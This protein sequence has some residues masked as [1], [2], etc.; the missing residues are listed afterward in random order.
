MILRNPITKSI[1]EAISSTKERLSIAV[2]FITNFASKV[3]REDNCRGISDKKLITRFD[4]FNINS[5]NVPALQ[6]LLDLGF[7][8][9]FN[10]DIHLKVYIFDESA[11]LSSSNLTESGF[12]K[13]IELSSV[14]FNKDVVECSDVFMN[15]WEMPSTKKVTHKLLADSLNTYNL[16]KRK[17]KENTFS[18]KSIQLSNK[19]IG[20]VDISDVIKY[21]FDAN[22]DYSRD[23][24][25]IFKS[26]EFREKF[27]SRV[28]SKIEPTDFYAPLDHPKR[29]DSFFYQVIYGDEE[30]LAGTGLREEH[31][32]SVFENEQL[33]EL[34][35][36]IYPPAIGKSEWNFNDDLEMRKFCHGLFDFKIKSYTQVLPVRLA[37]FFYPNYF[38]PIF[39][40]NHLEVICSILGAQVRSKLN[41]EKLYLCTSFL[42][43]RLRSI[44]HT[45]YIKS[46]ML[47]QVKYIK[48][49]TEL[50]EEGMND[51]EI[52]KRKWKKWERH[53][54][55]RAQIIINKKS[56]I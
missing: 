26:N 18:K 48:V 40:L 43:E 21:V 13:A 9:S 22:E 32:K 31:F 19:M 24:Q 16:L 41:G 34:I 29:N 14:L 52:F 6:R 8:I 12:E 7:Q 46:S 30:K 4:E 50:R 47:Y 10:N 49:L 39:S 27:K 1:E 17:S 53:L 45:N 20:G 15:I 54:L 38:F 51:S 56:D 44:P 11:V 36:F 42:N 33:E 3:L 23:N 55:E 25:Y 35:G 2:P 37:S 28:R 5:F